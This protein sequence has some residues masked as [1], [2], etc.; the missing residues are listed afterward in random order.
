[1]TQ[2]GIIAQHGGFIVD[3]KSLM[4]DKLN[5]SMGVAG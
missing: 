5:Q 3:G 1:M 2:V 4:K